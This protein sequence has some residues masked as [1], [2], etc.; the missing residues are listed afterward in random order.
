[1]SNNNPQYQ[2]NLYLSPDQQDLLLAALTS[3]NSESKSGN[4]NTY[5]APTQNAK[6]A[7]GR[8]S[9]SPHQYSSQNRM[10]GGA[11]YDSPT[12]QTPGSGQLGFGSDESPFLDYDI[13]ADADGNYDFDLPDGEQ[14][15]GDL[16]GGSVL[17]EDDLHEKRKSV[18]G[19]TDDDEGGG[20]RRESDDKSAKKPGRK[21]L[22]SEPTSVSEPLHIVS[23]SLIL[24]CY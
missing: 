11:L 6:S 1:M 9:S 18:D 14:M 2:Q 3:N 5:P 12:Q 16:P 22:T 20:K 17:G 19:K 23:T 10:T 15:I 13:D 7:S 4:S 8:A 24:D 21:P